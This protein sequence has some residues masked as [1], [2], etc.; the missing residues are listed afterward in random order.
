MGSEKSLLSAVDLE[1]AR[2]CG[3]GRRPVMCGIARR[4]GWLTESAACAILS[5]RGS[6]GRFGERAVHLGLLSP[7]QVQTLLRYQRNLQK[8]LGEY[9]IEQG[10][11]SAGEVDRLVQEML[12][13]N[14]RV[15]AGRHSRH[16]GFAAG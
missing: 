5:C 7:F 8:K 1:A 15:Q 11:L 9:F 4:W 10:L 14:A 6:Y 2:A 3:R 16:G 13:H 12:A